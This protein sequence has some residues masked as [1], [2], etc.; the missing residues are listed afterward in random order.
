MNTEQHVQLVDVGNHFWDQFS[1]LIGKA[2]SQFPEEI[3]DEVIA[4]LGERSSV[5][6]SEYKK[7]INRPEPKKNPADLS[8][9][10]QLAELRP[11]LST[12]A[13]KALIRYGCSKRLRNEQKPVIIRDVLDIKPEDF[14]WIKNAGVTT[15]REIFDF[16]KHFPEK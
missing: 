16:L 13:R 1:Q 7:Y 8:P 4:Y 2:V 11:Y 12:R 15:E 6:G 14:D 5:Y 3:E 10:T 9:N